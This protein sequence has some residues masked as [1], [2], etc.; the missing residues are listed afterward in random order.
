MKPAQ[1][2][3][4]IDKSSAAGKCEDLYIAA[5]LKAAQQV[6]FIEKINTISIRIFCISFDIEKIAPSL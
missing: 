4:R 2:V 1:P 3:Q 6:Y 5:T